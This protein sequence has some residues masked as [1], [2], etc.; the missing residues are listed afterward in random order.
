MHNGFH[1]F[2]RKFTNMTSTVDFSVFFHFQ[3]LEVCDTKLISPFLL[4]F[5]LA[6]HSALS[7]GQN[8]CVHYVEQTAYHFCA[9]WIPGVNF[10]TTICD[11]L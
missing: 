5:F 6:F 4:L 8:Y 11:A 7:I 2:E 10:I 3:V 9:V 1:I